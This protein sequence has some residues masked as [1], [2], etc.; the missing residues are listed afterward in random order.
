MPSVKTVISMHLIISLVVVQSGCS[1][2]APR[3]QNFSVMTSEPDAEIYINGDFV[4]QGSADT[5]V[6]RN[7]DVS[8]MVKKEGFKTT[9]RE[10]GTTISAVGMLDM[11]AGY[12]IL[13]PLLG[14]MAPGFYQLDQ[15][16]ISIV[17]QEGSK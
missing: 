10:V 8:I 7:K 12:L 14:F 16:N 1:F 5:R 2:L 6:P 4:G 11:I 3:R 9:T 17:L 13:L 15:D